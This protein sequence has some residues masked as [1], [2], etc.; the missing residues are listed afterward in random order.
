[1]VDLLAELPIVTA[2]TLIAKY[3]GMMLTSS[4]IGYM[5]PAR[6]TL[7]LEIG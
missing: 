6:P 3:R 5:R 1:M 4:L 2:D 7:M